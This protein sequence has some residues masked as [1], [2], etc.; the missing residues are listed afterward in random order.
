[1][2]FFY[3]SAMFAVIGGVSFL[4]FASGERQPWDNIHKEEDEE[5][6]GTK[7]TNK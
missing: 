1:M 2:I 6:N 5:T 4:I 7:L 3:I